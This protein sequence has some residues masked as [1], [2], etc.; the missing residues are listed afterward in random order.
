MAKPPGKLFSCNVRN[1]SSVTESNIVMVTLVSPPH[2]TSLNFNNIETLTGS[3][4][5]KWKEDVEMVLGLMDLDLALREE[6]PAAITA[7]STADHKAKVEK[8]ERTN[9]MSLMIMRKAMV[10]SVKGGVPKQDNAKD[11]LAAVGEKFKESDKAETGTFLTQIT[12][13][14]FDGEGSLKV[15]Y[16]TQKV[17]W[18]I[19]ELITMC[20]QEEDRL[21]SDKSVDVNFV[22]GEKRKRDFTQGSTVA[23]G[24]KKKKEISSS[25]KNAN[26]ISKGSHKIKPANGFS[27]TR[28]INNEVYNVYV[29]NGSKVAVES[30]GSVK[31]YFGRFTE[32][33]QHKGPFA[34]YLEQNGIVAQYTTPGT[35]HQNGVAERRNR[36][37]KDMIRSIESAAS[38]P[39]FEEIPLDSEL[40]D[41][42]ASTLV[43]PMQPR[44]LHNGLHMSHENEIVN[45]DHMTHA[46]A[47][48]NEEQA[49]VQTPGEDLMNAPATTILESNVRKSQRVRKAALLP[50]F[51]YLNEAE[52]TIGD[53][54]DPLTYNQAISS[55]RS[56]LWKQAMHE[57]LE[58][59]EKNNVWSLVPQPPGITKIIGCKWVFKTKRDSQGNLDKH[60]ARLVTKGFT[61]R[62]GIDYNETFSPVSTKDSMRIILAITAHFDLELHQMDVKMAFLNGDLEEDIYMQQAPGFVERGKEAMV[63]KLNKSI[64]GLKQASRQ[65]NKK[66]D[67]VMAASGFQENKMDECIYL[68]DLGEARFVLGIEIIRDRAKKSLGL[69]QR[70]YIDRVTKRFNMDKCS[71]GELPIGKGDKLSSDQC[72]KNELE[73]EGMK[74]KPYAS[75]VGSLMYAQVCTRP[76]LAFAVS[77]LGRFQSNPGTTHW[78]AAK[79]V[80]RYLKRTR[81][82]MLTYSYVDKLELVGFTDS[83]LAGCVDDRKSTNGYIFLLANGAVSWKSAKQK[84]IASST[85]EA[86]FIGC[87]AATQQAIWLKNMVRGLE[88]VDNVDRPLKLY[89]D[90]KAAVFFSKNNKR[91]YASRLM[92]IKYLK[93]RD[94]VKKETIEI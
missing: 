83:D 93:V 59:M 23:A 87:Y 28:V 15:S 76:D 35:P 34:T 7:E 8:W 70:Q 39:D 77:V 31:L 54:D 1:G 24:K 71:N 2:M 58:S 60:K 18:G 17:K 32:A 82:F 65:W 29:G 68:K 90:N 19:D 66:F 10:S 48:E 33:G 75:L 11:F 36:T 27:K 62:E 41:P 92:D 78:V 13:M 4:Y 57:E 89:C 73:N 88:I 72:P 26:I 45:E 25:F 74:D 80:L 47:Q 84:G 55:A 37:L 50:D 3:N 43:I 14:K 81:D 16:N 6:K 5:K 46:D 21:K 44:P 40:T 86:E 22:Q 67:Q 91:S 42:H 94:E 85:M 20:A 9:R 69:S 64:Y 61:Q 52:H 49:P 38:S 12:S 30:I 79:K 56:M 63:C 51:V 53:E